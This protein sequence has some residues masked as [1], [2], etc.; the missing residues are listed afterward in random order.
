[1]HTAQVDAPKENHELWQM[2]EWFP[3][4]SVCVYRGVMPWSPGLSAAKLYCIAPWMLSSLL[5]ALWHG[6][7]MPLEGP[8]AC[9]RTAQSHDPQAQSQPRG[10]QRRWEHPGRRWAPT[11]AP[12]RAG[13]GQRPWVEP[14]WRYLHTHV[15]WHSWYQ[16]QQQR[17]WQGTASSPRPQGQP[18][19]CWKPQIALFMSQT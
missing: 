2:S 3:S 7:T 15:P 16:Q 18:R 13:D 6:S 8:P 4:A 1:M 10:T 9:C 11:W 17:L 19:C 5:S 14:A 12:H